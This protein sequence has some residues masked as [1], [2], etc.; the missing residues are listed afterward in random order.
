MGLSSLRHSWCVVWGYAEPMALVQEGD[1]SYGQLPCGP[2]TLV[3]GKGSSL[4]GQTFYGHFL[5]KLL[6]YALH[7]AEPEEH[8]KAAAFPECSGASCFGFTSVT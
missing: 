4:H 8:T 7:G 2:I 5:L 6:Q 1:S 3:S